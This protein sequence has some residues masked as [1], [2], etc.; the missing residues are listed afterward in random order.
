M[1]LVVTMALSLV[2]GTMVT[3][4]FVTVNHLGYKTASD[5]GDT[6][7]ARL[8]LDSWTSKLRVAGWLDS[9]LKVDRFEQITPTKI[10]FWS[11]LNNRDINSGTLDVGPST[12][13]ALWI[14][15][16]YPSTHEGSLIEAIW[17]NGPDAAPRVRQLTIRA[18]AA[19]ATGWVFQPFTSGG[20]SPDLT[21]KYCQDS[22]TG[23][24][25]VGLCYQLPATPTPSQSQGPTDP[26]F[27]AG[28]HNVV[29]GPLVGTGVA[30]SILDGIGRIDIAVTISDPSGQYSTGFTSSAAINSGFKS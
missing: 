4:F 23:A 15:E 14:E 30:N 7:D 6:G 22:S 29:S 17:L 5:N 27:Q 16:T 3:M 10:V 9:S 24:A 18:K 20:T 12:K 26:V 21:A 8:T 25:V 1:E 13:V 11:N 19:N 28:T 2:V